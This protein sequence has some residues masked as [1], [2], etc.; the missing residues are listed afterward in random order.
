M[1]G[2][3][4]VLLKAD[5]DKYL[6]CRTSQESR[7][8][9]ADLGLEVHIPEPNELFIDLD[10]DDA[11]ETLY[12]NLPLVQSMFPIG[13]NPKLRKSPSGAVGHYHARLRTVGPMAVKDRII[14]QMALG[15]DVRHG[16]R[17]L[18]R[19][20]NNDPDPIL[21]FETPRPNSH[22]ITRSYQMFCGQT[23]A[24]ERRYFR[25]DD[26]K[27][28][29]WL[30]ADQPNAG[31]NVYYHDP[32]D[33]NSQ[34]FGGATLDFPLVDGGDYSAKGAWH[35]NSSALLDSTGVDVT[36]QHLTFVV[37]SKGREYEGEE[38]VML[39]VVYKD[40]A[41]QIGTFDRYKEI[42]AKLPK[43]RYCYY[44]ESHGGSSNGWVGDIDDS[45]PF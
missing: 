31:D 1:F 7:E 14:L 42:A 33:L 36:A 28:R 21:F 35:S 10:N 3:D 37:I 45:T 27:G 9:A 38:T 5:E 13:S 41:P 4:D 8:Y 16:L 23:E 24:V 43:G 44:S 2:I 18:S 32:K 20:E 29:V 26:P 34:G 30:V 19:V 11:K 25:H 15:G 12:R 40:E 6:L 17:S 39:D 22:I